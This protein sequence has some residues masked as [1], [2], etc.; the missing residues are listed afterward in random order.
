MQDKPLGTFIREL[1]GLDMNAAKEAFSRFLDEGAYNS[2]QINFVNQVVDYLVHN[3]VLEMSH[4]FEPPFTNHH[5]ESAYGFFDEGTV[6][7]LFSII[8]A[9]NANSEVKDIMRA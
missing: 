6:V 2:E 1:I 5:G 3:G 9:V 8:R 4:I 7:E